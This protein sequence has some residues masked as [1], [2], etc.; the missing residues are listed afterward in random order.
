MTMLI[1]NP[2]PPTQA[3]K[4]GRKTN[5]QRTEARL[6]QLRV[7][8][9]LNA[10]VR[11]IRRR[12]DIEAKRAPRAQPDTVASVVVLLSIG[13]LVLAT[14][15]TISYAT[16][17]SVAEWMKLPWEGLNWIVPGA[18]ELLIIFSSLD[19]LVTRSRGGRGRTPFWTMIGFSAIAVLANAAHAISAWGEE[20][21]WEGYV[22]IVLAAAA[23]F[24]VILITKR[25]SALVFANE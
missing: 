16:M 2:N 24:V 7:E 15:F 18:V 25:L 14:S 6:E 13:V 22:G 17:V 20:I 4:R 12:A 3:K 11:S 9:I 10:E 21:P 19:Y 5:A 23:P 8:E 1:T